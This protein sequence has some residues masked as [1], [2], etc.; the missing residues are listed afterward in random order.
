MGLGPASAQMSWWALLCAGTVREMSSAKHCLGTK[1]NL[2]SANSQPTWF[3]L[4]A[5]TDTI[6]SERTIWPECAQAQT[7]DKWRAWYLHWWKHTAISCWGCSQAWLGFWHC[8]L[9]GLKYKSGHCTIPSSQQ[10]LVGRGWQGQGPRHLCRPTGLTVP[11]AVSGGSVLGLR[12]RWRCSPHPKH[13]PCA[14]THLAQTYLE[15]SSGNRS[16]LNQLSKYSP[17][18]LLRLAS[19]FLSAVWPP[20]CLCRSHRGV[21]PCIQDQY[22]LML[23]SRYSWNLTLDLLKR[24]FL[25]FS[26]VFAFLVFGEEH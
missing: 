7:P 24:G 3:D 19:Q 26:E 4:S 12:Q 11:L 2:A 22:G 6:C 23:P 15:G 25:F 20:G 14:Q 21:R 17:N 5:H 16:K 13:L 9:V 8:L 10:M 18:T 1:V